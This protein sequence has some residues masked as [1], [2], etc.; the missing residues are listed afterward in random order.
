VYVASHVREELQQRPAEL[1]D[2][3][4]SKLRD[5]SERPDRHLRSLTEREEHSLRIG[6]YRAIID[7]RKSEEALYVVAFGHR[8]SV[9]DRGL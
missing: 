8:R 4:K 3:V 9:Y 5:A 7:W 1:R 2:R 6:D